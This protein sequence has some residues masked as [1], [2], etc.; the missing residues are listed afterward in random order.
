MTLLL[1]LKPIYQDLH[2]PGITSADFLPKRRAKKLW[3]K[4]PKAMAR[5]IKRADPSAEDASTSAIRQALSSLHEAEAR[6][7]GIQIALK[8]KRTIL[9]MAIAFLEDLL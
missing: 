4:L 3:R 9:N 5:I 6:A 8:K 2:D 7:K 1:F